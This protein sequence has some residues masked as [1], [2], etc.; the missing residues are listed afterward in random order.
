M[1]EWAVSDINDTH[2]IITE[3][4]SKPWE[5][6]KAFSR[7]DVDGKLNITLSNGIYVDSLNLKPA[8]QNKIRRM[9]AV[10]NPIYYKNQAIGT[11][12][13][14]TSQW[15]YLGKDHLSGY[16]EIPRG[17]Y[18]ELI[19]NAEGAGIDYEV[20]DERQKGRD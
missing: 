15:I 14:N 3:N 11:T 1:N 2:D 9:A 5:I 18:S 12:N 8:I 10:R 19:K 13:F 4:R 20:S 17:L 16:I 7:A 6:K